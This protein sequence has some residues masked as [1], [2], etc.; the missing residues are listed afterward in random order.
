MPASFQLSIRLLGPCQTKEIIELVHQPAQIRAGDGYLTRL[1]KDRT[2]RDESGVL[3]IA[4][5][6]RRSEHYVRMLALEPMQP[7]DRAPPRRQSAR[8]G[9]QWRPVSVHR[10]TPPV[11]P[12][13]GRVRRRS[14]AAIMPR[15]ITAISSGCAG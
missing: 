5:H 8:D 6:H 10:D 1:P 13:S 4:A 14:S 12:L 9:P 3:P 2:G 11:G 15:K 7:R